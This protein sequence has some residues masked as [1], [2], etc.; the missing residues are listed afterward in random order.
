MERIKLTQDFAWFSLTEKEAIKLFALDF[1]IYSITDGVDSLIKTFNDLD[2]AIQTADYIA[3]ECGHIAAFKLFQQEDF[4]SHYEFV[5]M[6]E[7]LENYPESLESTPDRWEFSKKLTFE[8]NEQHKETNWGTELDY[9]DE[10]EKFFDAKIK[11]LSNPPATPE[12]NQPTATKFYL[13]GGEACRLIEEDGIDSLKNAD[14]ETY[15][16][17]P[18]I[19]NPNDLLAKFDGWEAWREITEEEF[20]KLMNKD[21]QN[22]SN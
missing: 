4:E 7:G 14:F 20:L 5:A 19:D 2:N 9:F 12:T 11:E 13:F 22:G 10:L 18:M 8:F 15:M 17:N 1:E 21:S 6:L 3:L 16:F